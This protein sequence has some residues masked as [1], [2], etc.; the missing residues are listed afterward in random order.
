MEE[1]PRE[2]NEEPPKMPTG[3]E[4]FDTITRGGLPR[5]GTT[6]VVGGPGSGKTVFALQTVVNGAREWGEPGIFVAFEERSRQIV[7]NADSFGW[8][9]QGLE[10]EKLFF[11]D[12]RPFPHL[13]AGGDFDLSGLLASL[14]AKAK[15]MNARRIVFDSID[16][17]LTLLDNPVAERRELYRIH[18]WLTRSPLTG[19]ITT[20][21]YEGE[22]LAGAR[23]EFLQ[24]MADCVVRLHHRVSELVSLRGLR[25]VKYRGSA[26]DENE[27]PM[28]ITEDG[29]QVAAFG[30]TSADYR[31]STQRISTGIE[32]LDEMLNGGLY[33][34][35]TTLITGA[36]GTAK[37]TL[38]GSFVE[39]AAERGERSLYVSFDEPAEQVMRNLSSVNIRLRPHV[40]S[41]L[42]KIPWARAEARSAEAHLLIVKEMLDEHQPTCIVVDPLSA[43]IRAGGQLP[44]LGVAQR[45]LY[46]AKE[47]GITVV[48]TTLLDDS[49]RG[50]ESSALQVS[51]IADNWIYLS[52]HIQGG[53]RNRALSIIKARGIH[54]S[55]QVR[56]LILSDKGVT[57]EDVYSAGGEVLMGTLRWEREREQ[58][59]ERKTAQL[60]AERQRAEM[61][62]AEAEVQVRMAALQRELEARRAEMAMAAMVRAA[63]EAEWVAMEEARIRR[64][65][66]AEASAGEG[67]KD[68]GDQP[69][70]PAGGS[71]RDTTRE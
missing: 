19:I 59:L 11:L 4:G 15:E 70:S 22:G 27:V 49:E 69:S 26:F 42:L 48:C 21:L 33:R 18:D 31:V 5:H 65:S 43:M 20:R 34:A 46:L 47:R 1:R 56:E 8:N 12:A 17:L 39:A 30:T 29:I 13:T 57:L 44:A 35:T 40:E 6:L 9:L 25:V 23:H 16:V 14:D 50:Q 32:R 54:H 24:Y 71:S 66:T 63:Q 3:I 2:R 28:I 37:S 10:E 53:E 52:Y 38:A 58:E 51:T 41:G 68:A 55:N 62:L 36:P 61:E 64:R 7:E 67:K 45:L 60:A